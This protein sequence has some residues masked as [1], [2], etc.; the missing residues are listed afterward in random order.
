MRAKLAAEFRDVVQGVFAQVTASG[1]LKE[2]PTL[3]DVQELPGPLVTAIVELREKAE[4]FREKIDDDDLHAVGR[5]DLHTAAA[6]GRLQKAVGSVRSAD[7]PSAKA[8]LS[9]FHDNTPTA[10]NDAQKPL[11]KYLDALRVLCNDAAEQARPHLERA[12][13]STNAG[14]NG[15]AIKEYQQAYKLYSDPV[16]AQ[17]I[18]R[19]RED[20]LGL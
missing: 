19:L 11:W 2:V 17:V 1:V 16:T 9:L 20:S 4:A 10:D 14:Q 18:K 6:L 8:E 3:D 7:V 12:R 5:A 13:S 15:E